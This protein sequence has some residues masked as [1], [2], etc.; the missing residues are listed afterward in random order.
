MKVNF[1][2]PI[3]PITKPA[4]ASSSRGIRRRRRAG[5]QFRRRLRGP[6]RFC[7]GGQA[8]RRRRMW[9]EPLRSGA[10]LASDKLNAKVYFGLATSFRK[11]DPVAVPT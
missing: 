1:F 7:L 10:P 3:P 4:A 8:R 9:V 2:G 11:A 5:R 6:K